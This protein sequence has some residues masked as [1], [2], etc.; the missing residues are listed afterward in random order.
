[1]IRLEVVRD[2]RAMADLADGNWFVE[3]MLVA[4]EPIPDGA[5]YYLQATMERTDF[6]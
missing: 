3:G 1:M 4:R 6:A 2:G 5:F